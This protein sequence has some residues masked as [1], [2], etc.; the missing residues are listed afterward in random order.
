MRQRHGFTLI[1]LLVVIGIIGILAAILLPALARAREAARR[2]TCQNNLKQFGLV[3]KM[4]AGENHGS[5][6]R[7]DLDDEF[8]KS[9]VLLSEG[10]EEGDD[11]LN[12]MFEFTQVFP[13]Y[14]TDTSVLVCPSDPLAGSDSALGIVNDAGGHVCP[15]T[16]YPSKPHQ[17][18]LYHGFVM[19][20]VDADDPSGI[21]P[22]PMGPV[23][24]PGQL[25]LIA[26]N[27]LAYRDY[28]PSNDHKIDADISAPPA[29]AGMGFGN[30]GSD[31]VYRLREGI[32]RFLITDI[33]NPAASSRAQSEMVTMWDVVS[34]DPSGGA[35]FNHIPGGAN[36]LFLDGHVVF[37][38]Y[39]GAF[40]A[41]PAA[42][43]VI[44]VMYTQ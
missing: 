1:E 36:T 41:Y 30:G 15:W 10:C 4:Y 18:Y 23:T 11:G 16:N 3:L 7:I 6:P 44:S 8:G 22:T 35:E 38:R 13:E 33:N 32:E 20:R 42:A 5:Y 9:F 14:L 12:F 17:S 2:A 34:T 24:G 29:M 37:E 31:T 43:R 39:P 28:D 19:D 21:I 25:F 26:T 27:I 40:P